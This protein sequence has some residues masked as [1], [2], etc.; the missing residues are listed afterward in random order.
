LSYEALREKNRRHSDDHAGVYRRVGSERVL[1]IS[2]LLAGANEM[3]EFSPKD[4][5]SGKVRE[6]GNSAR[7]IALES[8]SEDAE[9]DK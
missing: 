8:K 3:V 1:A 9:R 2:L 5:F 6:W 7:K 4:S